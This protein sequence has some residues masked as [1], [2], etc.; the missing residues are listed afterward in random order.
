MIA[1]FSPDLRVVLLDIEGTTTPISFVHDTLFGFA[2]AHL[3]PYLAANWSSDQ[4]QGVVRGL[5]RERAAEARE[6]LGIDAAPAWRPGSAEE[7]RESTAAYARWLMDRDRKSPALKQLQGLIWEKGYEAGALRGVVWDDVPRAMRRWRDAGL[8]LA[9]YSSGSELAQRRL[10]E[11]TEHGDLTP[12]ISAF[13][14]TAVGAKVEAESYGRIAGS[15][16]V[17]PRQVSFISDVTAELQA[18]ESAGCI[19][20]LSARSGNPP[21]PGAERFPKV[22]SFDEL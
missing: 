21:Q 14:D 4:V 6:P 10:F 3:S 20:I 18:A 9:I 16:G 7:V 5:E 19:A 17:V 22:S 12:M 1:D 15:L 11:S 8:T 2:R 13:F